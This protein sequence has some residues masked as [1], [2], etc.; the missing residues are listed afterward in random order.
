[1]KRSKRTV[2]HLISCFMILVIILGELY[3]PGLKTYAGEDDGNTNETVSASEAEYTEDEE[4]REEPSNVIVKSMLNTKLGTRGMANP[5]VPANGSAPWRGSYVYYGNYSGDAVKYR[6]LDRNSTE[7]S[8]TDHTMMMVSNGGLFSKRYT[9]FFSGSNK[10]PDSDLKA[11]LNGTAF[12]KDTTVFSSPE[13]KAIIGSTKRFYSNDGV[14]WWFFAGTYM[15]RMLGTDSLRGEKVFLLSDREITRPSYGYW[16]YEDYRNEQEGDEFIQR[17]GTPGWLRSWDN[18]GTDKVGAVNSN[19]GRFETAQ[20]ISF[21]PVCP[22][23][24]VNLDSILFST[25][26]DGG[27]GAADTEYK[28]TIIDDS[29]SVES[30]DYSISGKTITIPYSISGETG[31]FDRLSVLITDK[32]YTNETAS[33]KAY[34]ELN[35]VGDVGTNG[36]GTFTIPDTLDGTEG[37]DYHVYLFTEKLN[38]DHESDY[39]SLPIE[40]TQKYNLWIG[41]TQVTNA[42]R[43]NILDGKASYDPKSKTLTLNNATGIQGTTELAVIL[44]KIDG[45]T[46]K[47]KADIASANVNHVGFKSSGGVYTYFEDIDLNMNFT[48]ACVDA[49]NIV[50]N[51]G[52][53]TA[54]SESGGCIGVARLTVNDGKL[55]AKTGNGRIAIYPQV[56]MIV[57]GGEVRAEAE[58]NGSCAI[59]ADCSFTMDNGKVTAESKGAGCIGMRLTDK[60]TLNNGTIRVK[61]D[62]ETGGNGDAIAG[63]AASA[64][65]KLNNGIIEAIGNRYAVNTLGKIEYADNMKIIKPANGKVSTDKHYFEA[66]GNALKEVR[67][68]NIAY[69]LWI[70]NTVRVTR[71]NMTDILNDGKVSYDPTSKTLTFKDYSYE[72]GKDPDLGLCGYTSVIFSRDDLVL[73]GK[74]SITDRNANY[75]VCGDDCE[76]KIKGDFELNGGMGIYSQKTVI[77]GN[78]KINTAGGKGVLAYDTITINSGHV[79]VTVPE[80]GEAPLHAYNG[81]TI[82]DDMEIKKPEG[83]RLSRDKANVVEWDG[84]LPQYVEIAEIV[85]KVEAISISENVT[86]KTGETCALNVKFIPENA[87]DK[88]VEWKSSNE[89]V[90]KVDENGKVT[91]IAVGM[92]DITAVSNDGG[93]TAVC[94]V[95]VSA[96]RTDDNAEKTFISPDDMDDYVIPEEISKKKI[97]DDVD[98]GGGNFVSV[99]VSYNFMSAVTYNGKVITPKTSKELAYTMDLSGITKAAKVN[100]ADPAAL[101]N[102]KYVG[103]SKKAGPGS[104]YA[105]LSY[106]AKAGREAK[107]TGQQIKDIKKLIKAVNTMLKLN[108]C[109]FHI[110]KASVVSIDSLVVSAKHD[111]NRNIKINK[112]TNMPAGLSIKGKLDRT[113]AK[114][115]KLGKTQYEVSEF[116]ATAGTIKLKGKDNLTGWITVQVK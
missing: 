89:S 15:Y 27:Y 25:A 93:K 94:K 62:D 90:A 41:H 39:A 21:R 50:L 66:D 73:D 77:E 103:K 20:K 107:L 51:S 101:F 17:A 16:Y 106:N 76:I 31:S 10:W 112:K 45:L 113:D 11:Y 80:G 46:I 58:G 18:N 97:A 3:F 100:V 60:M 53:I 110:N 24:N 26:V 52:S 57:N 9:D 72:Q 115:K 47:G 83:G 70:G 12:L 74:A 71:D 98:L 30:A 4:I 91:G 19:T 29:V 22:A 102:V 49:D 68:E 75:V 85:R 55:S 13:E 43:T 8:E 14:G 99:S 7:Y 92:A 56:E 33:I 67:V 28:L 23:F 6:V 35:I 54:V 59:F 86:I 32:D 95:K 111:K 96:A 40:V 5:T 104:F 2:N 64:D 61:A 87:A 42:N 65:I 84:E 37:I 105:K 38:G 69:D 109:R 36:S 88:K 114:T 116:N 78:L 63:T 44:S 48:G 82:S 1:M 34:G 81:I 108:P 79:S